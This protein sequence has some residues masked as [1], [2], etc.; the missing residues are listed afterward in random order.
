MYIFFVVTSS[1]E[2]LAYEKAEE[3]QH[4]GVL[5]S[6][7]NY[8]SREIGARITKAERAFFTSLKFF[9]SKLF[10]KR[11]KVRLYT[12]TTRPTLTYGCEVVG[13]YGCHTEKTEDV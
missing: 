7:K 13:Q 4:L 3:F 10:S 1:M 9:K 11:T 12:S 6:T 5:L 8:W 2:T